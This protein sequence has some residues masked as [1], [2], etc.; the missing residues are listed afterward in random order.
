MPREAEHSSGEAGSESASDH[1]DADPASQ[2][3]STSRPDD[4]TGDARSAPVVSIEDATSAI[5][6]NDMRWLRESSKAAITRA[7]RVV[8]PACQSVPG[9]VCVRV[10]DASAM[11]SLHKR[12][13]GVATPTD[14]L[15]FDM[16]DAPGQGEPLDVDI[17]VC[18][19]VAREQARQRNTSAPRELLLYILHGALHCLGFDDHDPQD[20][21]RM[22]AAEDAILRDIGVGSIYAQPVAPQTGS[23]AS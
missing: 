22:H 10:I 16:R 11:A 17:V 9:S 14:V 21:A 4:D 15:T 19:A 20:A 1:A 12:A 18:A 23:A 8:E 13:L 5:D 7:W 3:A 2:Y 6:V